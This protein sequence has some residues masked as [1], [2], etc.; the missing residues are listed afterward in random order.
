ML[1]QNTEE[2]FK[3]SI[4]LV[5]R[6]K[7]GNPTG[8]KEFNTDD[9][10]ELWQFWVKHQPRRKKKL[11]TANATKSKNSKHKKVVL[12]KAAEAEAILRNMFP[13]DDVE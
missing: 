8:F 6:D 3:F 10:M 9:S 4:K 12:P 11:K 5:V 13:E 7:N 2:L 1:G